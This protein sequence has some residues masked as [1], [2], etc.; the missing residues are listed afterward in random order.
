MPLVDEL[1]GAQLVDLCL[2]DGRLGIVEAGEVLVMWE[3]CG[4][5]PVLNCAD[6][7]FAALGLD[8]L[9]QG[10]WQAGGGF[11]RDQIL[12]RLGHAV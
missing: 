3:A 6:I 7:A 11:G 8:K 2:L 4:A 9:A 12:G 10:L 1:P 5:H